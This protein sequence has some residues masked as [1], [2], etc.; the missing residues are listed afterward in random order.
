MT[1]WSMFSECL[2]LNVEN[3]WCH[4]EILSLF[5]TFS[6]PAF[7]TDSW[8]SPMFTSTH[9]SHTMLFWGYPSDHRQPPMFP[10]T[11]KNINQNLMV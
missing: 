9:T 10:Q 4:R 8:R 2:E 3:R 11:P 7:P 1:F 6:R 5:K